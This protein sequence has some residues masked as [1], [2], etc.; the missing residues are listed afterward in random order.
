MN[1]LH[2]LEDKVMAHGSWLIGS[3]LMGAGGG[4]SLLWCHRRGPQAL[5]PSCTLRTSRHCFVVP[6]TASLYLALLPFT[7]HCFV[8][9]APPVLGCCS[10]YVL[11]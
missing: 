5:M 1:H 11:A 6:D 10:V 4:L 7:W 3:W 8:V 2:K 9:P